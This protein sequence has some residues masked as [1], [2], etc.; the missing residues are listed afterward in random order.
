VPQQACVSHYE[1][2][3]PEPVFD[4][5]PEKI[6]GGTDAGVAPEVVGWQ[7]GCGTGAVCDSGLLCFEGRCEE[8]CSVE[9]IVEEGCLISQA[10]YCEKA[11]DVATLICKPLSGVLLELSWGGGQ[12]NF[13]LYFRRALEEWCDP[14]TCSFSNCVDGVTW[15]GGEETA[16]DPVMLMEN[17]CGSGPETIYLEAPA[18][19]A[20]AVAVHRNDTPSCVNSDEGEVLEARVKLYVNGVHYNTYERDVDANL[21]FWEIGYLNWQADGSVVVQEYHNFTNNWQCGSP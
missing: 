12:N 11:S 16:G 2:E 21:D 4:G 8:P 1:L 3:D 7:Q 17:S 10:E 19:G 13:D 14:S 9:G 15:M 6:D 20:Y 18:Q 5:G